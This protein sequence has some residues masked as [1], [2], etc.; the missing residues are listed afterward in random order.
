MIS[1]HTSTSQRPTDDIE[2]LSC[3]AF[4]QKAREHFKKINLDVP[5]FEQRM[6]CY[7]VHIA[8]ESICFSTGQGNEEQVD[9]VGEQALRLIKK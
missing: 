8:L 2:R 7:E 3:A 5:N 4:R 1:V 6:K 9:K